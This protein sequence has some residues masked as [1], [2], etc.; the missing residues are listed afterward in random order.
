MY[1]ETPLQVQQR[2]RAFTYHPPASEQ[3]LRYQQIRAGGGGLSELLN[4]LCPPSRELSL[5]QTRVEEAVMWANAA[6]ARN[7]T[8]GKPTPHTYLPPG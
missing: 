6:I 7:E 1:A 8:N 3:A 5:A 4:S 2:Q